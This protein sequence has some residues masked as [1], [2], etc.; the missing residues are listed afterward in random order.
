MLLNFEGFDTRKN[1]SGYGLFTTSDVG[2]LKDNC[3]NIEIH[4]CSKLPE[5]YGFIYDCT[6]TVEPEVV[7][8]KVTIH[9]ATE[10]KCTIVADKT[11]MT[12]IGTLTH[13]EK[14]EHIY[15]LYWDNHAV[16]ADL[17]LVGYEELNREENE[18]YFYIS[19]LNYHPHSAQTFVPTNTTKQ[20]FYYIVLGE[21]YETIVLEH[22]LKVFKIPS[23]KSLYIHP[24]TWHCPP[25]I[26]RN[27]SKVKSRERFDMTTSQSREH[28]CVVYN[29]LE[30]SGTLARF[31]VPK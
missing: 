16:D 2:V 25:I 6:E 21:P 22:S 26:I 27:H 1:M 9:G 4:D 24:G 31:V 8:L 23:N 7:D 12:G 3:Q 11:I 29:I 30:K 18:S 15:G 5:S 10:Y 17:G 13:I 28:S 19:E 14:C 20:Y